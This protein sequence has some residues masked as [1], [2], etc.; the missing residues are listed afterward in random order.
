MIKGSIVPCISPPVDIGIYRA[1]QVLRIDIHVYDIL[2]YFRK[3]SISMY[4]IV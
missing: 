3:H 4:R 1:Y 2:F